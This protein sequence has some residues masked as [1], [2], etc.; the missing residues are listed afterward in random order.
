M[1]RR[2][3]LSLAVIIFSIMALT[4]RFFPLEEHIYRYIIVSVIFSHALGTFSKSFIDYKIYHQ[5]YSE[6]SK[7]LHEIFQ[8]HELAHPEVDKVS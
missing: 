8:N 2:G 5:Q 6:D 1:L 4:L 3:A 7:K